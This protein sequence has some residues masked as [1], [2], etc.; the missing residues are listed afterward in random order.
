MGVLV[1]EIGIPDD[2]RLIAS[3]GHGEIHR[4]LP[5]IDFGLMLL[6]SP[7]DAKRASMPTK[8]GEFFAAGVTPISYG[9]NSEVADWVKRAGSGLALDDLS[10]ESLEQAANFVETGVPDSSIRLRARR[11]AEEHFSLDSGAARYDRLFQ[12]ILERKWSNPTR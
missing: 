8:L 4:W 6:V 9:G 3:V 7:N 2:R 12:D 10:D 5:W 1:D 11:V